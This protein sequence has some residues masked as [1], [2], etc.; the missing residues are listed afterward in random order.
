MKL[1][2]EPVTYIWD[3]ESDGLLHQMTRIHC[4]NI[5]RYETGEVW[6][7]RYNSVENT[8]WEGVQM[9][10]EADFL[11]GQNILHF[12]IPALELIF[13]PLDFKGKIRDTLVLT[14]VIFSDQKDKDF[15]LYEKGLLPGKCI[16]G[17]RLEDWGQRLGLLKATIRKNVRLK[18]KN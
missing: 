1:E 14:R 2:K 5:R 13:G 15:R 16:G 4:L 17:N 12:D 3:I 6:R 18:P 9:L 10:L 11:V 7:F 8:I